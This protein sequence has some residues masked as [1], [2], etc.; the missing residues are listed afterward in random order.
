MIVPLLIAVSTYVNPLPLPGYQLGFK[1]RGIANGTA[2]PTNS[3]E[4]WLW[5]SPETRQFREAADPSAYFEDGR[6]YL[7]ASCGGV[8]TSDDFGGSWVRHELPGVETRYAP[9]IV[10][11]RGRYWL[12]G[13]NR[14][15]FAADS[16]LGP[17]EKVGTMPVEEGDPMLFS[18]DDG[19]LYLYFG[20]VKGVELDPANPLVLKGAPRQLVSFDPE[21]QPWERAPDRPDTAWMEGA[22]VFKREGRYYLLYS[23]AGTHNPEYAIG[24]AIS[25]RPLGPFVRQRKNPVFRK[26][27]GLVTGTAH[28]SVVAYPNG[29]YWLFYTILAG[30]YHAYERLVGMDRITFDDHGE[31][32]PSEATETPQRLPEKP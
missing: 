30:G 4:R 29:E 5:R 3:H 16:P 2:L 24:C 15:L 19:R 12:L 28:G 22:W 13:C 23:A 31:I 6:L 7:Y 10:R 17:F 25:D 14:V 26:T 11:H 21:G 1:C 9:T 18:D 27:T 8:W 32:I 20:D